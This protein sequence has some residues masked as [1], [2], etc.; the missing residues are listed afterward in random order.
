MQQPALVRGLLLAVAR[1][2]PL[3]VALDS[4]PCVARCR[5]RYTFRRC[6]P[7]CGQRSSRGLEHN[8][9]QTANNSIFDPGRRIPDPGPCR[10]R[11]PSTSGEMCEKRHAT[12]RK[13]EATP[14]KGSLVWRDRERREL[15]YIHSALS[16]SLRYRRMIRTTELGVVLV[17][18]EH[19][20][21][22]CCATVSAL[23]LNPYPL[24]VLSY[25]PPGCDVAPAASGGRQWAKYDADQS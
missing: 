4:M 18:S 23:D 21:E 5:L 24:Q 9:Q 17:R 8:C 19:S 2:P 3:A 15:Q 13:I 10:V 1:E 20:C 14:G 11:R 22:I 12:G 16:R 7:H 6:G 25:V